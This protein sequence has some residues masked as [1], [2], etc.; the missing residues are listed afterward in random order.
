MLGVESIEGTY[1]EKRMKK[2]LENTNRAGSVYVPRV[3]GVVKNM[4]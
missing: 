3:G 4:S 1:L 2:V